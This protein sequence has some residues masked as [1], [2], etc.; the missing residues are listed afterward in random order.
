MKTLIIKTLTAWVVVNCGDGS[1]K[2]GAEVDSASDHV[3]VICVPPD[4]ANSYL[5]VARLGGEMCPKNH[6]A[7]DWCSLAK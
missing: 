6:V 1:A 2:S 5:R 7:L 4:G 3:V